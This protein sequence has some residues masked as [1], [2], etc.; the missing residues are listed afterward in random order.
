MNDLILGLYT[1][2]EYETIKALIVDGKLVD[3]QRMMLEMLDREQVKT[4]KEKDEH[5][6]TPS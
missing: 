6:V 2:E 1:S 3:A 5:P 4:Q